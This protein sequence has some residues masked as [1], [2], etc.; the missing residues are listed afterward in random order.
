MPYSFHP[1]VG[2]V[3]LSFSGFI[4]IVVLFYTDRK[5]I[6]KHLSKFSREISDYR[7]ASHEE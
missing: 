1:R 7:E 3:L 2:I 5:I 4:S 6:Y